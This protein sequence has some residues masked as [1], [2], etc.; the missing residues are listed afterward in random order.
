MI[1]IE[2]KLSEITEAIKTSDCSRSGLLTGNGGIAVFLANVNQLY[3]K[4]ELND[5]MEESLQKCFEESEKGPGTTFA[6]GY[7]GICWSMNHLV[8]HNKVE[9]DISSLFEDIEPFL[10]SRSEEDLNMSFFDFVLGGLGAGIYFLD[11]LP[12]TAAR[13]HLAKTVNALHIHAVLFD[14]DVKWPTVTEATEDSQKVEYNLGLAH[15]IPSILWFLTK[16]YEVKIEE[17]KCLFLINGSIQWI[18][19]QKLSE[20][21]LSKFPSAVEDS[22]ATKHSRLGWCYG[23]LGIASALWQAGKALN[24][25]SWKQEAIDIMLH[26]GQRKDHKE[27]GIFDAGLCHGTA[28]IAHIFNRFYFETKMPVFKETAK[29]WIDETL[30]M[31]IHKDGLAGFK[32]LREDTGWINE[33]GLLEGVSGIGLSLYSF[34]SEEEPY[35]DRCLLLS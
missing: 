32:T 2:E 8:H 7:S 21:S 5:A 25:E 1:E 22:K 14:G 29:H 19:K 6:D 27:N 31:A 18:L 28:G 23:D 35:W 16:C 9:A 17:E 11:R 3:N 30:K 15:G 4:P 13:D 24:N 34:L 12:D 20:N 33:H 10:I 26:A